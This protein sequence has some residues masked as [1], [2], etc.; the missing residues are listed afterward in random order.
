M[1]SRVES[2]LDATVDAPRMRADARR[3]YELLIVAAHDAFAETG[4]E[5]SMEA[6]ARRAGVG[7]GTLYRHFPKRIDLVEAVYRSDVDELVALADG[8]G[9]LEPWDAVTTFLEGFVRYME[10]KRTLLAELHE[11]FEKNP[12]LK[13]DSR[14]RIE[15]A[16]SRV[17]TRAQEEGVA[18]SDVTGSDILQMLSPMCTSSTLTSPQLERLVGVFV[19]GLRT[20][21]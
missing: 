12:K 4:S 7:L 15:G 11:A 3:N 2:D 9:A 18:R 21:P 5:T 14:E 8:V 10:T 13:V 17:L 1:T 6:I 19:D 16:L 20:Q